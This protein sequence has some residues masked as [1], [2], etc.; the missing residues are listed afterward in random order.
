MTN[1]LKVAKGH[2]YA[3][4][5]SFK[6]ALL[7]T[8]LC[9]L[10]LFI[11]G[12]FGYFFARG[13][14]I[15]GTEAVIDTEIRYLA[16]EP[17]VDSLMLEKKIEDRLLIPFSANG[18]PPALLSGNIE[19]LKEGMI[20]FEH[21]DS[22]QIYAGKIHTYDNNQ[23]LLVAIDITATKRAFLFM[24]WLS[25]ISIALIILVV[26]ASYMIS[27]FVARGTNR[28]ATT[29]QHIMTTGDLSQRL[30]VSSHWDDLGK[31]ST[32]LNLMLDR[33]ESLMIGLR[34]MSDNIAHDLRTP[35]TRLRNHIEA[36]SQAGDDS[37]NEML[38][39]EADKLLTTF[40]ALL[41]ISRIETEKKRE[42]FTPLA[43]RLLIEDVIAF[44][45]PLA[46]MKHITF[47]Q[48]LADISLVGDKDLL[49]QAYANIIDNAIKYTPEHGMI[50][51]TMQTEG[52]FAV[53][54][55]EDTGGGI[56]NSDVDKVFQR[57]YRGDISRSSAGTG[58]G[59]SLVKAVFDLHNGQ[60][61]L[62]NTDKGLRFITKL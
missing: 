11:L 8:V 38:L 39:D 45:E 5:S 59:L 25:M 14:F 20:V 50:T 36:S 47:H 29:A 54:S 13:H 53:V 21:P 27:V 52:E 30:E 15:H 9:G 7:F 10:S 55:V 58:L 6:M 4:S 62:K 42:H 48:Q 46:E 49:F 24:Q 33:I 23:K 35:L 32:T 57:F 56:A 17:P 60:L 61:L 26:L 44:Y 12:Y 40:N 51:I 34:Q 16:A 22:H 3:N 2:S 1:N 41:R 37:K 19:R 31:M 43:L 28:I 18:K